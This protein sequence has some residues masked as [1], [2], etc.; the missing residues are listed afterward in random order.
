MGGNMLTTP[1]S[2]G[3]GTSTKGVPCTKLHI[4][5]GLP[6]FQDECGS[7][8]TLYTPPTRPTAVHM[9]DEHVLTFCVVQGMQVGEVCPMMY[10]S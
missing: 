4:F 6:S 8:S 5:G 2:I 7:S 1:E 3:T 9:S 10:G